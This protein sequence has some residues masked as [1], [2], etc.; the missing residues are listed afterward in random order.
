M[1]LDFLSSMG[2]ASGIAGGIS[3]IGSLLNA[4]GVGKPKLNYGPTPSEA[5]AN[6]L[7]QALL[8]PNNSLVKQNADINMQ[9]GMQDMLMQL[10]KMQMLGA[11]GQARGLNN[12]FFSPERADETVNYLLTRGQTA[13]ADNA[14]TQARSDIYNTANALKGFA[15]ME[16][17]RITA[18][19]TNKM[20]DAANFQTKG[21]YAQLGGGLQQLLQMLSPSQA[22]SP[23]A[24][25][26]AQYG[27]SQLPWLS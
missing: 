15:P 5:Q 24:Y 2:G 13:I 3:G 7:F 21:G 27:P 8:D 6:S 23:M 10:K 4:L 9:K 18:Q 19:N 20:T 12:P 14:R 25:N 16:Q 26:S 22:T 1:A 11:R 17:A